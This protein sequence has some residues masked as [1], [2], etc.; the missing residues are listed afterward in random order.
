MFFCTSSTVGF[1]ILIFTSGVSSQFEIDLEQPIINARS[2]QAIKIFI[3]LYLSAT[4][5]GQLNEQ[6][7]F[8]SKAD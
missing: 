3:I 7:P 4:K 2:T 5:K 8:Q 1:V 6:S